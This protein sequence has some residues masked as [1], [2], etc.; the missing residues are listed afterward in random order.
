MFRHPRVLLINRRSVCDDILAT[1]CKNRIQG[2]AL[3]SRKAL[4][5]KQDVHVFQLYTLSLRQEEIRKG[6]CTVWS[7]R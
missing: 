2:L 1:L 6:S 3:L 5:L 7:M 4:R